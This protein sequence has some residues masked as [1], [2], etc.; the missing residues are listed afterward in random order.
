MKSLLRTGPVMLALLTAAL[1]AAWAYVPAS[2]REPGSTL[3]AD[4]PD[5]VRRATARI[6][7]KNLAIDDLL[8]GQLTLLEAA[9]TFRAI[10]ATN[11]DVT[12]ALRR[13]WPGNSDAERICR[14]V[15]H[16]AG[17]RAQ[18][19]Q[20]AS[21]AELTVARLERELDGLLACGCPLEL[22]W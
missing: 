15:I 22:P 8:D 12:A 1:V 4:V 14:Q 17:L 5:E 3:L 19:R 6:Q 20:G 21:H 16:W 18:E 13:D 11:R 7:A 10:N 9:A 2:H